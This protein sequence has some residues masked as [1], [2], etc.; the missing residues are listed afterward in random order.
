MRIAETWRSAA[1]RW[2]MATATALMVQAALLF[3]F[4]WWQTVSQASATTDADLAA[5]CRDL[6]GLPQDDLM[7]IIR[8]RL[9]EDFNRLKL[10]GLFGVDHAALA[11]NI[12]AWPPGLSADRIVH[13][14]SITRS[15]LSGHVEPYTRAIA[16]P[17]AKRATLVLAQDTSTLQTQRELVARAFGLSTA[18]AILLALAVGALLGSRAQAQVRGVRR[19]TERIMAGNLAERLPVRGTRDN[20]DRLSADVNRMLDRITMLVERVTNIGNDIAHDLRTPLTR[21][22]AALDRGVEEAHTPEQFHQVSETALAEADRALAIIAALLRITEIE[23][24]RRRAAFAMI[25]LP[26]LLRDVAELY[27][28]VAEERCVRLETQLRSGLSLFG[29]RD[30]FMEA[31]ANLVQNAIKFSP[32]HGSV[33]LRLHLGSDGATVIEVRDQGPG[34][35]RAER[36]AVF[37]RFYRADPSR[38]SEGNGLGLTL[39]RAIA[40]LHDIVVEIDDAAPGCIVRLSAPASTRIAAASPCD[41]AAF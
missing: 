18:P 20:L 23:Q 28:P 39:V 2:G 8:T 17:T 26:T 40:D 35:P 14:P 25:D 22:R 15:D 7:G 27:A 21:L 13:T 11:G 16:C 10:I 4:V 31:M 6:S 34:I 33:V 3:A 29:D 32:P 41:N 24:A 1:F 38:A 36:E 9:R 19:A 30:L 5:N 12:A 37:R